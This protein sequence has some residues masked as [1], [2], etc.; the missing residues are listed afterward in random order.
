[1]GRWDQSQIPEETARG[2]G[3]GACFM[4]EECRLRLF[5][6]SVSGRRGGLCGRP[7]R[8]FVAWARGGMVA[9]MAMSGS[10]VLIVSDCPAAAMGQLCAITQ[11]VKSA[12]DLGSRSGLAWRGLLSSTGD[13]IDPTEKKAQNKATVDMRN[14]LFDRRNGMVNKGLSARR[15]T[16]GVKPKPTSLVASRS[17]RLDAHRP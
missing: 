16:R 7:P 4:L 5:G 15:M 14:V 11:C 9:P 13:G 3:F 17:I 1:M 6:N 10:I 8:H 12:D 2:G